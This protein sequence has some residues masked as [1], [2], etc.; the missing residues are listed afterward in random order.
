MK[1]L[2]GIFS[3]D[4]S[5]PA[6]MLSAIA[7]KHGWAVDII[8][9]HRD[10]NCDD[11]REKICMSSADLVA[12]SIKTFERQKAVTVARTAKKLGIKT[13]AGGP[14]PT[15]CPDDLMSTGCYDAVVVGDGAGVF[16]DILDNYHT[17]DKV[18]ISGKMNPDVS[19]YVDRYFSPTQKQR[20]KFSKMLD[21]LTTVGCPFDCH[22]CGTSRDVISFPMELVVSKIKELT[23]HYGIEYIRF[24]DDTFTF[25]ANRLMGFH[26]LIK[27]SGF[28]FQYFL[29]ARVNCFNED[30]ADILTDIGVDDIVFGVETASQRLLNFLNKKISVKE[31]YKVSDICRRKNIAFKVNI[32]I[33]IPTQ[34]K[35]D[36]EHTFKFIKECLPEAINI[37]YFIPFPGTSLYD[38]CVD[39]NHMPDNG[40][41]DD[42]L[43]LEQDLA[44]NREATRISGILKNVDYDMA[45]EYYKKITDWDYQRKDKVIM[46]VAEKA[47]SGKW[48]L[49]GSGYYFYKV[50]DRLALR[51]WN[52]FLGY[53]DIIESSSTEETKS[54]M[55]RYD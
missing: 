27:E 36:Y 53:Y 33:G 13:I 50:L 4:M 19:V 31:I 11:I 26:K 48:I 37:N 43:F 5:Y 51:N 42:Y 39:N 25:N 47:D 40:S 21:I 3:E 28:E 35:E 38:Y 6:S 15:A 29:Q 14:H 7:V 44:G 52:N 22:F 23:K 46:S 34:S 41:F 49:F 54:I 9:F 12:L 30:I 32:M 55:P 16:E 1:L 8:Y 20:L 2:F 24:L 17:L 18:V 10:D 45:D